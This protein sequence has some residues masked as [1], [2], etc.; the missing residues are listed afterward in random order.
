LRD[1]HFWPKG[2]FVNVLSHTTGRT[3]FTE[4]ETTRG[5]LVVKGHIDVVEKGVTVFTNSYGELRLGARM[6]KRKYYLRE[7]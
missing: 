6:S 2:T 5:V 1:E 4:L 7:M 3:R